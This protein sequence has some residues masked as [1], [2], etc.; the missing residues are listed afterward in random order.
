MEPGPWGPGTSAK[1]KPHGP[2]AHPCHRRRALVRSGVLRR[3]RRRDR[4]TGR[5][6]PGVGRQPVDTVLAEQAERAG[7][8][9]R[10]TCAHRGRG[11]PNDEIDDGVLRGRRP[12]DLPVHRGVGVSGVYF[13]FD[14]G[15]SWTSRR[16]PAGAPGAASAPR[17][18]LRAWVRSAPCPTTSKQGSSPTATRRWHSDPG[19]GA[20]GTFSWANGS[21]LYY[22][23][24]TSNF[25]AARKLETFRGFEAIAV[26]TT[27]DVR[28]RGRGQ[29][30]GLAG[31]GDHLQAVAR[32]RSRTRS[33]SMPTTP[34]AA[35]SSATSTCAGR[36]SAATEGA[37]APGTVDRRD[38]HRRRRQLDHSSGRP[39]DATTASTAQPDGC[40]VRTDSTGTVYVFGVGTRRGTNFQMMY[41]STDGG[42]HWTGPFWSR[43]S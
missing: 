22:A 5:R 30:L 23:N 6:H 26:S 41:R 8:G 11:G 12:V 36:R 13:S 37:R 9:H 25:G 42:A 24:L 17:P 27:D 34:R 43:P 10:R 40:V 2:P 38:I 28:G 14:G 1:R 19:P 20:G 21:R 3:P 29:Q 15:G 35:R 31:A 18:A 39:G 7:R 32:R 33:R 16:T 4:G